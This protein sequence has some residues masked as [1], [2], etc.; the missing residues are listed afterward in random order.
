MPLERAQGIVLRL[1]P[2][3]ETSLIVEWLTLEAGRIHTLARGARRPKSPLRGKLDVFYRARLAFTR[4]RRSD[5]H[6]LVEVVLE[7]TH[8]GLR[9]HLNSLRAAGYAAR[10]VEKY[11][12]P[13]TPVPELFR[14]L[15]GWLDRWAAEEAHLG[16]LVAFEWQWLAASGLQP[17]AARSRL[18][19]AAR[20]LA[21]ELSRLPPG[22]WPAHAAPGAVEGLAHFLARFL[23]AH[24]E[25]L[26]PP[27]PEL[28][29]PAAVPPGE[30]R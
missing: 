27:R 7:T 17:D 10:F 26:P 28:P 23:P 24:L 8:P 16:H 13:E 9:R 30:K 19:P 29:G 4:A 11:A 22:E 5:L 1:R 21:E 2:W 15:A 20:Q 3:S 14:L 12:E 18:S 25:P 6:T